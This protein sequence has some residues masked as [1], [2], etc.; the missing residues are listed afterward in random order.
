VVPP[1]L[2]TDSIQDLAREFKPGKRGG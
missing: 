1:D 2:P